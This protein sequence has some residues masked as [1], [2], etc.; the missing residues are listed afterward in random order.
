[1][2]VEVY[3]VWT[4]SYLSLLI[5]V[6]LLT[7]FLRYKPVIIFEGLGYVVTWSLLIWARGL[8]WMQFMEFCY[9]IATSTEVAYYTYI[10]AKV[11]SQ[12]YQKVTSYTR[13]AI[14]TGRFFSGM[15]AQVSFYSN[16]LFLSTT[17]PQKTKKQK[18]LFL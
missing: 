10:Y 1:M 3:P 2:T 14:L 16:W 4:Y 13:S 18:H 7:D 17:L 12:Y 15:L 5:V 11:S 9:G 8:R 6:F